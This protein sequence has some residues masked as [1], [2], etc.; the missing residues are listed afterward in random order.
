MD[1]RS[2][3]ARLPARCQ[4]HARF[5]TAAR[6]GGPSAA[7]RF[8]GAWL[9]T[10]CTGIALAG[11]PV[12]VTPVTAT[13]GMVVAGHPEAAAAGVD[14]LRAGGN[15]ID[16]AVAVSLALGVA[17]PYASGLG[18]KIMMV[19]RDAE[20]RSFAIDGMDEASRTLPTEKFRHLSSN[21]RHYGW[22][23][24]ATPGL[25]AALETAH[26]RWGVRPWAEDVRPAIELARRG[27]EVLPKSR[28]LFLE[29]EKVLRGDPELTRIFLPQGRVPA[30]GAR[31]PNPDLAH[32]MELLAEKGA[33]GFYRGPVAEAMVAAAQ[34]GGGWLTLDDL[35]HYEA[36]VR[37]PVMTEI[38]GCTFL[39]GCPPST[40]PAQYLAI[41]KALETARWAPGALRTA[42]NL[43]QV[44]RV[45]QQVAPVVQSTVADVASADDAVTHLFAAD[46]IA[47]VRQRAGVGVAQVREKD[48]RTPVWSEPDFE[49]V[50]ASTTHFV[51]VDGA[52]NVV[53]VTQSQSL[54]F[55]AGVMAPGTGVVMNDSLSNFA[56]V[57]AG[58]VNIA[59]PGKRPRS[60]TA[61]TIVVRGG[62]P[63]LAIGLP[64]AQRIP[65]AMLQTL[66]DYFAFHRPLAD[67]I[68]DT[69]LHLLSPVTARDPNN[70]WEVEASFPDEEQKMLEAL[71]WKVVKKE[72]AGRGRYFG[73]INAIE[74]G[75]DGALTGYADPRRT[76]AA[77]G[78]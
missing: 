52:G 53:S 44:G 37:A 67:S 38:F 51:I 59:A 33:A 25:A 45:W 55:G 36:R 77:A 66:L 29:R 6:R 28:D 71:G 17:E 76:N 50:H 4:T 47:E 32:T 9:A 70:V 41:L 15:A 1:K 57:N 60:T 19:Y 3:R 58:S 5:V 42:A 74:V 56:V 34:R 40:G 16:A 18:G 75:A 23:S 22:T 54:H 12:Q 35:A 62:R 24:V 13:H 63:L 69:R 31:L 73:G 8:F 2:G 10:L 61:P 39:A 48:A 26:R 21:R 49:D 64:G 14:V 30:V 43:D 68:G 65:T 27:F 78:F 20:G 72:A 7:R 11:V 46:F